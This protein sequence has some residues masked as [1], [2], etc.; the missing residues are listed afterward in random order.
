MT[1][2]LQ[3]FWEFKLRS[4]SLCSKCFSHQAISPVLILTYY[5]LVMFHVLLLPA[6]SHVS[7]LIG[8]ALPYFISLLNCLCLPIFPSNLQMTSI[9]L[10]GSC[11]HDITLKIISTPPISNYMKPTFPITMPKTSFDLTL[12]NFFPDSVLHH[13]GLA[14]LFNTP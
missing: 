5:Q 8:S 4:L 11:N 13:A 10:T 6:S 1:G 3:H 9:F 12:T 14:I 2:F 7:Y